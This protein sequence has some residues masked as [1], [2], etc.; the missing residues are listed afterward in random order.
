MV[1]QNLRLVLFPCWPIVRQSR[2]GRKIQGPSSSPPGGILPVKP[3]SSSQESLPRQKPGWQSSFPR[4]RPLSPRKTLIFHPHKRFHALALA[5]I[6]ALLVDHEK[7][8][9]A[10]QSSG[11]GGR[12][13]GAANPTSVSSRTSPYN[14]VLRFI[15]YR[16]KREWITGYTH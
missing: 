12:L 15:G 9:M 16:K 4:L 6:I 1:A 8:D 5:A 2:T 14:N 10:E 11:A 13:C 3:F 7:V